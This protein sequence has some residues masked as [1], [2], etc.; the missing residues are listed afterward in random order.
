MI[1]ADLVHF[2]QDFDT[3]VVLIVTDT[4]RDAAIRRRRVCCPCS[5]PIRRDSSESGTPWVRG[6]LRDIAVACMRTSRETLQ[7]ARPPG[8]VERLGFGSAHQK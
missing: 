5:P 6:R 4:V 3:R 1:T 8:I 7:G 2:F